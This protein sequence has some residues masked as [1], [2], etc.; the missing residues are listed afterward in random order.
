[1]GKYNI[2]THVWGIIQAATTFFFFFP[3]SGLTGY[4]SQTWPEGTPFLDVMCDLVSMMARSEDSQASLLRVFNGM[5]V[6]KSEHPV[7]VIS[8]I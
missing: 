3:P 4:W 7:Q 5:I 2:L 8:Q 1:M 6:P